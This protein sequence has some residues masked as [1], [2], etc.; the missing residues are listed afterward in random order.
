M[1]AVVLNAEWA[2]RP[3]VTVDP[4]QAQQFVLKFGLSKDKLEGQV[5]NA[6]IGTVDN[7]MS[8]I[9]K[10]IKFFNGR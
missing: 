3:G 9:E 4:A 5:Y 1:K 8:E 2:P 6:I 7:L 10:S